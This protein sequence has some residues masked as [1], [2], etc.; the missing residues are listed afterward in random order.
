M[1]CSSRPSRANWAGLGRRLFMV[2]A[3][4]LLL[5]AAAV[6]SSPAQAQSPTPTPTPTPTPSPT[7]S[8]TPTV[9]NSS[10]SAGS[11]V[12]NLGSNFLERLG[13]QATSGLGKALG[14]NPGGGGASESTEAPQFRTWGELY[15]LS[16]TAGPLGYFVGDRRRTW[17]GVAGLGARV[18]PGVNVGFSVDQ[19]RTAID[20]PLALQSATL[21]LTQLGF[22]AS[23]DKGPWTWAIALVHGFGKVNSSR[24]TGFGVATAGYNARLDGALTELSY[25]WSQDQSRIVPKAAF[26]YV[27]ASTGSL[28]EYGGLDPVAASGATAARARVLVGAEIGHYWIFDRKILDLSAYGK[29]VD[30]VM[31]N[32]G[33]VTVSLGTQSILVQGIGESRYGADA[34]ASASLSLSNT[35]R[36][37]INYDG[38]YRASMQSHQGTLGVEFR[39]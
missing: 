27:R 12:T 18:A 10:F 34:G 22:S 13:N 4:A 9:I 23:V 36:L 3:S 11:T 19:S 5:A 7:P 28:Q 2:F 20:I 30:N 1:R 38:K 24:D 31:Q 21:D 17:G 32:F 39:W 35:A 37:Y 8:P 14:S 25:Y 26:E 29:F 33:A 15:G 6:A 16:A